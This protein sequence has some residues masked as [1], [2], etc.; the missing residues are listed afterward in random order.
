MKVEILKIDLGF[1]NI[2]VFK[3]R[4]LKAQAFLSYEKKMMHNP[5]GLILLKS[6]VIAMHVLFHIRLIQPTCSSWKILSLYE[7]CLI[8]FSYYESGIQISKK[9]YIHPE[10]N[11]ILN[12]IGRD[13]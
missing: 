10:F 3:I 5:S 13:L 8:R 9:C 12:K 4:D 2:R 6:K 7:F 1:Y 11:N